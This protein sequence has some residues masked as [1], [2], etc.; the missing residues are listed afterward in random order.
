MKD[1]IKP[2]ALKKGDVIA[3]ISLSW[4]GAG[5]FRERYLQG[6]KQFEDT[7]GV[8]IIETPNALAGEEYL[9]AHPEKRLSDLMWALEQPD[10]KG[11]LTNIGGDDTIRLL[12]LMDQ[13][14]FDVIRQ[15][16]KVFMGMSDTTV[17]HFMYYKAGVSSFYAPCLMFGY[18]ENGG[19]P[20]YIVENTK[21][22]L[23]HTEPIG[24]LKESSEFIAHRVAFG[25]ESVIR[26]RT[27]SS[28]WR[29]IQGSGVV[30]GKLIGGC[31]DVLLLF[32]NKTSL[33]PSLQEWEN[34]VLFLETSEEQPS[35]EQFT[36][37][38]QTLGA[39][40]ILD[41]ICGILFARPGGEFLS[42]EKA[43]QNDWIAK[44]TDYD[45]AILKV[46]KEFGKTDI[47]VVTN[48]D[49][50]HTVP[51]FILPYGALCQIDC[52]LKTVSILDS[53]VLG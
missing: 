39:Q 44:Y 28:P 17:N 35:V 50:G 12:A 7:F 41:V 21:K 26:E 5:T 52:D 16:P 29:Y 45:K 30:Q 27:K 22:T 3:T 2:Q 8:K 13:K 48:M 37:W 9:Y 24:V 20:D 42:S 31:I 6:K 25:K 1:L 53:G 18:A 47:P 43:M 51:Q 10:V 23:F 11:I 38:M 40:G 15:N 46:L 19:I 36:S 34:T 4:G 32:L 33:W 49:F 14:H